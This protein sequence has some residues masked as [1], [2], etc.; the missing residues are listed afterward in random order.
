MKVRE[1]KEGVE[2]RYSE[3]EGEVFSCPGVFSDDS[4]RV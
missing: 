3:E 1:I 2:Y 4:G